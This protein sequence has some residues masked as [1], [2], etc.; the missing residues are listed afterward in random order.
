MKSTLRK[1]TKSENNIHPDFWNGDP[2]LWVLVKHS[3][4]QVL[5]VW[6]RLP[7]ELNTAKKV[8]SD[9]AVK[10]NNNKSKLTHRE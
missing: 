1:K 7:W 4:D 2:C 10:C 5:K 6:I 9:A 8:V 3:L